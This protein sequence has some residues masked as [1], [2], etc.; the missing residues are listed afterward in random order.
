M[1]SRTILLLGGCVV[2]LG[3]GLLWERA[4]AL[5]RAEAQ[6]KKRKTIAAP[7]SARRDIDRSADRAAIEK[8]SRDFS[9]AFAKGDAKTIAAMW[10]DDGE[11]HDDNGTTLRGRAEIEKAFGEHFKQDSAGTTEVLIEAIRFPARDLAVED[12]LLRPGGSG[13]DLPSSTRY[14][15]LHVREGGQWKIAMAREW[16]AGQD[17]LE[18]LDWLSGTWTAKVEDQ[19]MSLTFQRD[20]GKSRMVGSFAKKTKG[21]VIASGTMKVALDPQSGR[22]RSWHFDDDGGHG[23][24]RWIRD[25]N[26]WVLDAVGVT[27]DGIDTA[28]I[29]LLGRVSRDEITWRSIDRIAGDR[30]LPDTVPVKLTRVRTTK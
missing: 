28:G 15:V 24:A 23:Q 12:G 27:A 25:G 4:G 17:R 30:A 11:Y 18:D 6:L 3:I 22:L 2:A 16:G 10:T 29:N 20:K 21:K 7:E 8:S 26:L 13:K 9:A 14:S 5:T 19:E 1:N